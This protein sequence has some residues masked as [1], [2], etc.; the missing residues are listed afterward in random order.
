MRESEPAEPA[1]LLR[2]LHTDTH[3]HVVLDEPLDFVVGVFV[4]AVF[5]GAVLKLIVE[6]WWAEQDDTPAER[7]NGH[8]GLAAQVKMMSHVCDSALNLL[9]LDAVA[10]EESLRVGVSEAVVVPQGAGC[11]HKLC[12]C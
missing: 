8:G 1:L 7:Q 12:L 11:L 5:H 4:L 10:L 3:S 9:P 2:R 6:P